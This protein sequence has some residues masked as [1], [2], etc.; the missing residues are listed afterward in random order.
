MRSLPRK[1]I[2]GEEHPS[3]DANKTIAVFTFQNCR[4]IYPLSGKVVLCSIRRAQ[5][6]NDWRILEIIHLIIALCCGNGTNDDGAKE[7]RSNR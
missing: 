3:N 6:H 4:I 7:S 5:R 2:P 1:A